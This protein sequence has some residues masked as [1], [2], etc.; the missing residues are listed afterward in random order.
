MAKVYIYPYQGDRLKNKRSLINV[1]LIILIF[2]SILMVFVQKNKYIKNLD[3]NYSLQVEYENAMKRFS[4]EVNKEVEIDLDFDSLDKLMK[5][6][7]MNMDFDQ[8]KI[9]MNSPLSVEGSTNN[10]MDLEFMIQ[11]A[12]EQELNLQISQVEMDGSEKILFKVRE[13]R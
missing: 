2:F 13:V 6:R 11:K 12:K 1:F 4:S 10:P 5:A 8:I 3:K 7:T 9:S